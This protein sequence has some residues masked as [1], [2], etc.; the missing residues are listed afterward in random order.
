MR[1]NHNKEVNDRRVE[2]QEEHAQKIME[3]LQRTEI[4]SQH[5]SRIKQLKDKAR[6]FKSANHSKRN[7][8]D[9]K[10]RAKNYEE[11]IRLDLSSMVKNN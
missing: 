3:S 9:G 4:K 7:S 6:R 5:L 10:S 11:R 2:H 8:I 1:E